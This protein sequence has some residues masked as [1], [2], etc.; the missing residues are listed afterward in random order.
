MGQFLRAS[1]PQVCC[2]TIKSLAA[3][4]LW[5]TLLLMVRFVQR[6]SRKNPRRVG[7]ASTCGSSWVT[8]EVVSLPRAASDAVRRRHSRPY[9]VLYSRLLLL[10]R[11]ARF[12]VFPSVD[13]CGVIYPARRAPTPN[14][15]MGYGSHELSFVA[16]WFLLRCVGTPHICPVFLFVA[17]ARGGRKSSKLGHTSC[18]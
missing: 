16:A 3:Y 10:S 2:K 1:V 4:P 11:T 9:R 17:A 15:L 5:Q 8:P 13:V 14:F 18:S 6:P 12:R 7:S